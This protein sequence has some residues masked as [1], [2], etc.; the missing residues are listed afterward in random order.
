MPHTGTRGSSVEHDLT[1][2]GPERPAESGM[3]GAVT[4]VPEGV[5]RRAL[6]ADLVSALLTRLGVVA[7]GMRP[8]LRAETRG[9]AN[10]DTGKQSPTATTSPATTTPI[11]IMRF[12]MVLLPASSWPVRDAQGPRG[13]V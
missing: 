6:H 8:A 10:A 12:D 7:V 5:P 2:G 4:G 3:T 13:P 1:R 9:S 11:R